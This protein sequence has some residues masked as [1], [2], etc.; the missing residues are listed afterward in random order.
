MASWK[1]FTGGTY[2]GRSM[3]PAGDRCRNLYPERV[4][5]ADPEA[6]YVLLGTPGHDPF[7]NLPAQP[8]QK[9]YTDPQTKRMFAVSGSRFYEVAANGS[10]TDYGLIDGGPYVF[11]SNSTQ[12]M[13]ACRFAHSGWI[14]TP[15][16]NTL[17]K[18]TSPGFLGA[19]SVRM[20]DNYFVV[21]LGDS[22]EI[23]ICA[24]ADGL[25]WDAADITFSESGPDNLVGD[26]DSHREYWAF[27]SQRFEVFEDTGNPLFPF[28]RINSIAGEQGLAGSDAITKID[29]QIYWL[30]QN[31][32]GWARVFV[33]NGYT[34]VGVSDRAVEWWFNQYAKHGGISDAVLYGYQDEDGHSFLVITFPSATT[35]PSGTGGVV[36][37]V[38]D[39]ATWVYDITEKMWHERFYTNPSTG[40]RG[41]TLGV[42]HTFAFG[43]HLVGG[44]DGTG[45]I[46][47]MSV[48]VYEDNG[49]NIERIRIAPHINDELRSIA[50]SALRLS[51][52]TGTG[53]VGDE[54]NKVALRFSKD[55]G[56][57][58]SSYY[59]KSMG[60][61]G[62]FDKIVEWRALG[63]ARRAAVE[64]STTIKSA[65]AWVDLFLTAREGRK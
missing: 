50:F 34:P 12:V 64:I 7:A 18:I 65:V 48:D 26:I 40:K 52:Q 22:R 9:S 56:L 25:T 14:F 46:Y 38:V 61:A 53:P 23:Q 44:G 54:F 28:E 6:S 55:G 36:T 19:D 33:A 1:G 11:A 20:I 8:F 4:Q 60:D 57:N 27:G 13:I 51:A 5:S 29:S 10:S 21:R 37:G 3:T 2:S 63:R 62:E 42:H 47:D 24:P 35:E 58:W 43:K 41:K 30:G 59:E 16:T 45:T 15:L 31:E 17:Q 32:N 39:G 49:N